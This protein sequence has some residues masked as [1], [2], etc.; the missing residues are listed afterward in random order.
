MIPNAYYTRE[1]KKNPK[2]VSISKN[3]TLTHSTVVGITF[4]KISGPLWRK[5][6]N[7]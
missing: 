4:F 2:I 7:L 5:I 3:K 6:F 1:K